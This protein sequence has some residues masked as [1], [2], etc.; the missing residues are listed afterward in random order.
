[1]MHEM[2]YFPFARALPCNTEA[3]NDDDAIGTVACVSKWV[4]RAARYN[5][6]RMFSADWLR[7]WPAKRQPVLAYPY[8]GAG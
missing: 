8:T 5:I 2:T 4:N 3:N 6:P 7:R 1:M